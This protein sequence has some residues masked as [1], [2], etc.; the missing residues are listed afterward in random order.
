MKAVNLFIFLTFIL[1]LLFLVP[2][3]SPKNVKAE[4]LDQQSIQISWH[5][6]SINKANGKILGYKVF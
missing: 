3:D 1:N 2:S 4:A 5:P 6:L